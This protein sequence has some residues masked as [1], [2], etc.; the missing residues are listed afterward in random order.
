MFESKEFIDRDNA[1]LLT[2]TLKLVNGF[3]AIATIHYLV[4]LVIQI[5]GWIF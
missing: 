3:V 2:T 1:K 4:W 5:I